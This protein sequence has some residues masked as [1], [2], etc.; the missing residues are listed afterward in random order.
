MKKR[1][2]IYGL[3]VLLLGAAASCAQKETRP[4]TGCLNLT[5]SVV[6]FD[7]DPATRANLA[8]DAFVNGERMKLK[9]ICPY[10]N[11]TEF[12]ETTYGD[13]QDAFW[14]LKWKDNNWTPITSAD[15]VDV[16]QSYKYSSARGLTGHHEA[17]QTPYV[18]TASTWSENVRF[19]SNGSYRSQYSY[20][21]HADQSDLENY[22]RSDLLWA[23]TYMQTGA[24]NVHLAFNHVL[25]CLKITVAGVTLSEK[26]VLTL[27]GMPDIDQQEIVVGDYYAARS[28]INAAFGYKQKTS[29]SKENNGK[30]LGVAVISDASQLATVTPITGSGGT[31]T[32]YRD[33]D[34]GTF[35]L[36][37]PPCTQA[38][39]PK[40]W[41]RDGE[42]RYSYTLETTTFE[43]GKQ[44]PV[45][46]TLSE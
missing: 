45:N 8:G 37:V 2:I 12:G 14:L 46:I 30:V 5:T 23:Q 35:Y 25:S 15:K 22:R 43:Q 42:K 26:A 33:A 31:Y 44:Y 16:G 17:Q 4:E 18:Y 6:P 36:I 40:I 27:E 7:G 41:I 3:G 39:A 20:V 11:R 21:F 1:L 10:S 34:T 19:M 29:C 9:I 13:T 28:K 32:A 24:F 38:P